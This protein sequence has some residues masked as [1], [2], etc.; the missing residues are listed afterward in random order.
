MFLHIIKVVASY[1]ASIPFAVFRAFNISYILLVL[2]VMICLIVQFLIVSGKVKA[3]ISLMILTISITYLVTE[4]IPT[5][6]AED[7]L[8]ICY[9]NNSNAI[10]YLKDSSLSIIG[11]DVSGSE[12]D[13]RLRELKI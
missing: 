6:Y 9:S 10:Y 7:A 12:L 8:A 13:S 11:C 5:S 2:I 3:L 1:I 4:S